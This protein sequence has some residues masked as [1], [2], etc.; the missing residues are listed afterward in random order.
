L[1]LCKVRPTG[2]QEIPLGTGEAPSVREAV[3]HLKALTG[4]SSELRFGVVKKRQ[5]EPELSVADTDI[6]MNMG[7]RCKYS[8]KEGFEN[9]VKGEFS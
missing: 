8:W 7:F 3:E 2:Y 4:S 5:L 9:T 1:H 6:L